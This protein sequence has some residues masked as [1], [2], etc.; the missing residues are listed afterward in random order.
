MRHTYVSETVVKSPS[1]TSWIARNR[2]SN[3]AHTKER[4]TKRIRPLNVAELN[5]KGWTEPFGNDID[6]K[7]LLK[8]LRHR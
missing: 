4:G 8:V 5:G 7:P 1:K 3:F 2:D 6:E